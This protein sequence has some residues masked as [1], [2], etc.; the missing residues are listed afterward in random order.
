M[1]CRTS[2]SVKYKFCDNFI[3]EV[4]PNN[5]SNPSLAGDL[6]GHINILSTKLLFLTMMILSLFTAQAGQQSPNILDFEFSAAK[7][8]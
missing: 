6:I 3:S 1:G 4:I 7:I 2:I 8:F 5:V